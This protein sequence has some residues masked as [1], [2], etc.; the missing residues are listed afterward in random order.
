MSLLFWGFAIALL[1]VA[2]AFIAVP[3][4]TRKPLFNSP[5]YLIVAFIPLSAV[6][7]YALLGSPDTGSERHVASAPSANSAAEQPLGSV[8]SMI[9]GLVARLQA[10][11][12]DADGWVLLARSYQHTGQHAQA[13][14]AYQHAKALGKTDATLEAALLGEEASEN[15]VAAVTGTA[16][17][18]RVALSPAAIALVQPA[19]T[20]FIFAKES[21]EHRMPVV[22]LR[23][24]VSEMPFEF[25]LTDKEVMVPGSK[26]SDYEQ[27]VVVAKISRTGNATDNTLNLEAWSEPVSPAAADVINLLIGAADE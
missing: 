19:D 9:D 23:K 25:S 13:L 3:L 2:I 5:R 6:G 10:E 26:L 17:R 16:L 21:R 7:V 8:A 1:V 24:N 18:G 12:D 20:L 22:A 11:P 4:W 15:E 27:L 14:D